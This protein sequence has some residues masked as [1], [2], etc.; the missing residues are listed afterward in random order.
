VGIV[1]ADAG[2]QFLGRFAA[3]QTGMLGEVNFAHPN[4]SQQLQDA[5]ASNQIAAD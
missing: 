2:A 4:I 5:G 3:G 1:R